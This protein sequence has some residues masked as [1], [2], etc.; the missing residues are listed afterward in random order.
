MAGVGSVGSVGAIASSSLGVSPLTNSSSVSDNTN[1]SNGH[2]LCG[3]NKLITNEMAMVFLMLLLDIMVHA[4]KQSSQYASQQY[5]STQNLANP[6]AV[7]TLSVA[8]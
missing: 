1:S 7:N 6:A 3:L 5:Q 8:A 4:H 2:K